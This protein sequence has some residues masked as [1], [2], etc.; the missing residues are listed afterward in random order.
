MPSLMRAGTKDTKQ[1][2]ILKDSAK[3]RKCGRH[4]AF[5]RSH[6]VEV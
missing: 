1:I 5:C 6:R 3:V 2:I 4:L